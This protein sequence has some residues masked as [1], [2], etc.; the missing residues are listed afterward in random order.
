MTLLLFVLVLGVA[1]AF[2][3]GSNDVSKGV[4]TLAGSGVCDL[5]RAIRWGVLWTGLGSLFSTVLAHAM[6]KTFGAGL[7]AAGEGPSLAA[8]LATIAGATLWVA[9]SSWRGWPV[10][11]THAILGSIAGVGLLAYGVHGIRWS[12]F[13]SR[14]VLPL[15][16]S[17]VA[18]LVLTAI[19][20][21]LWSA[22]S[23]EGLDCLCVQLQE[24]AMATAGALTSN[25]ELAAV[26]FVQVAACNETSAGGMR[27][28]LNHLHWLTSAGTSFAR[29]L[30]DSPKMVALLLAAAAIGTAPKPAVWP[31]ALA[32]A[33]GIILGSW[34]A[35]KKVTLLLAHGVTRMNHREG[36]VANLVTA[37]LVGP[38][39][40]LGLPMSTTHVAS[41][42]IMGLAFGQ[43]KAVERKVV[44]NILLAW[45][46]TLPLAAAF[47]MAVFLALHTLAP[48]LMANLSP[49][50]R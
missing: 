18:A 39:A 47:G 49:G 15:L 30:N 25:L 9:L 12:S 16:L 36:F 27:L 48:H 37:G 11:T 41:G 17:P 13:T 26:P 3:N 24:P 44:L 4:A 34:L 1:I 32:V 43:G 5:Q 45:V 7:L 23:P 6:L 29:G 50:A 10:S 28:S 40:A 2:A 14:L 22:A 21:R 35:G 19:F 20:V 46:V 8:A 31:F 38:G 42:A 33:S